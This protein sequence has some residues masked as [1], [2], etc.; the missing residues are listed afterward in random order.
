MRQGTS[1]L[2]PDRHGSSP[3]VMVFLLALSTL[4]GESTLVSKLRGPSIANPTQHAP[5]LGY[6]EALIDPPRLAVAENTIQ[7]P[8]GWL[9]FSG[10]PTG[11]RPGNGDLPAL[12]NAAQSGYPLEWKG[13][14]HQSARLPNAGDRTGKT[15]RNLPDSGIRFLEHDGLWRE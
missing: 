14:P 9:P 4:A 13:L 6:Y 8:P 12:A 2:V 3:A 7:P 1:R 5:P 10:E 11:N 15:E